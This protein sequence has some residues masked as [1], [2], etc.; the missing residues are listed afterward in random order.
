MKRLMKTEIGTLISARALTS[1][2]AVTIAFGLSGT[3]LAQGESQVCGPQ[4]LHGSYV[5]TA[6]GFNIVS[7][8]AQP[9]AIVEG[10]DFNGD[11]TL[12]VP[13]GTVSIN[14]LIIQIP[15]G[16]TGTYTL[17]S[18]CEGTLTFTTGPVN[19]SISVAHNG[20]EI[21][22]IQTDANTVFQGEAK[23]VAQ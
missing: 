1:L 3:A 7:G 6:Q 13:F 22:M 15:P 23:K 19:Y 10:I 21:F 17:D 5:F 8:V 16:G 2:F 18:S 9:K 20:R 14:G 12:T 11:A 4:T